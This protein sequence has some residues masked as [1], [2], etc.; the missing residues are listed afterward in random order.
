[1]GSFY[2]RRIGGRGSGGEIG[3]YRLVSGLRLLRWRIYKQNKIRKK[4][5]VIAITL[6]PVVVTVGINGFIG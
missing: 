3:G 1:M 6:C 2:D 4:V 5:R